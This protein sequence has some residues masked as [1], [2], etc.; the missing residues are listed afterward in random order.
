M[1]Y[2]EPFRLDSEVPSFAVVCYR[3]M[4]RGGGV[5]IHIK[6]L[7]SSK[8]LYLPGDMAKNFHLIKKAEAN[9]IKH[10]LILVIIE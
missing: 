4:D 7:Q 6:L 9:H 5:Y 1:I 8:K 10:S 2:T 3:K